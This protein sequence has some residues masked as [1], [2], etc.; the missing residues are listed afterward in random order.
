M[1]EAKK[2]PHV[3]TLPFNK[4]E[5]TTIA[6]LKDLVGA[7]MVNDLISQARKGDPD[8]LIDLIGELDTFPKCSSAISP[9]LRQ[10]WFEP[11]WTAG[12]R[13]LYF[14]TDKLYK[15]LMRLAPDGYKA[16]D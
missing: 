7:K 14:D 1:K 15:D 8:W 3:S 6:Q 10:Y 5:V 11:L 2:I 12:Y 4:Q 16:F 9:E 13:S